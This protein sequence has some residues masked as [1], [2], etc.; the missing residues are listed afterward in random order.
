MVAANIV[1]CCD[2]SAE[3]G[4]IQHEVAIQGGARP[5]HNVTR[6]AGS[7]MMTTVWEMSAYGTWLA[8]R[9]PRV[10]KEHRGALVLPHATLATGTAAHA[11]EFLHTTQLCL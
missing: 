8:L 1:R 5:L 3:L 7:R 11:F 2:M 6:L 10:V 9:E 4:R